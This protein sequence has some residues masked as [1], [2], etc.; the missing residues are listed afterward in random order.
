[1][2]CKDCIYKDICYGNCK[3]NYDCDDNTCR[4]CNSVTCPEQSECNYYKDRN[5]IIELP[6][7]VGDVVYRKVKG[8][9]EMK[10]SPFCRECKYYK[11]KVCALTRLKVA[12]GNI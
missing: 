8:V 9:G 1:M 6:C 11:K 5:L 7:K 3:E 12:S 2:T 4:F 10:K